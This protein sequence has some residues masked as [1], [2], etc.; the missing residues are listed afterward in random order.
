VVQLLNKFVTV[1][2]YTDFVPIKS[3]TP[4][5]R[6]QRAALNQDRLADLGEATNPYYVVLA[7]DGQVL[8][9][10]GGYNEP[11][12]FVDFLQKALEKLPAAVRVAQAGSSTTP[13]GRGPAAGPVP[14]GN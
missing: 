5:Q 2:L 6:K 7:P 14:T 11:A 13:T 3:I 8:N 10:I 4:D 9:R 1:Q 12:V